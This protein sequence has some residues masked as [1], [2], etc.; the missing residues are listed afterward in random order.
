MLDD[1]EQLDGDNRYQCSICSKLVAAERS[2]K[3]ITSPAILTFHLKRFAITADA[4]LV[5][6]LTSYH[7]TSF[8]ILKSDTVSY[9]AMLC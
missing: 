7:L 6:M 2:V 5:R 3:Y 8:H 9:L 1:V 4:K